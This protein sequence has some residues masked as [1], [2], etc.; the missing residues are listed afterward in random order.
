MGL[1]QCNLLFS[2]Y[3]Y[4]S[5]HSHSKLKSMKVPV[6]GQNKI[7]GHGSQEA[8]YSLRLAF[9]EWKGKAR[10]AQESR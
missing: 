1:F 5:S 4:S 10:K 2:L 3:Q 6:F 7:S 8:A 9:M